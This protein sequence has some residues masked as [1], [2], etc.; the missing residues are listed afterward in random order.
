MKDKKKD[1]YELT[2]IYDGTNSYPMLVKK[3]RTESPT[4]NDE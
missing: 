3:E 2:V 4:S 1:E